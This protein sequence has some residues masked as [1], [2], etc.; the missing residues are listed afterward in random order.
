MDKF[1]SSQFKGYLLVQ[2]VASGIGFLLLAVADFGG[3][4]YRDYYYHTDNYGYFYLGSDILTTVLIL[5]GL[6]GLL[7]SL[8]AT[9]RSLL[10]KDN[11]TPEMLE[12]NSRKASTYAGFTAFLSIIS[13]II[14][15]ISFTIDGLVWWWGP[16]FY[17]SFIGGFLTVFLSKKILEKLNT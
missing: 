3:F 15:G 13:A 17:G 14:L 10:A 12:Y 1:D 6:A 7:I 4:Y 16:G 9:I 11:I 2:A 5:I 8:I